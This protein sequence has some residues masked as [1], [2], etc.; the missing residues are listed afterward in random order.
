MSLPHKKGCFHSRHAVSTQWYFFLKIYFAWKF[1]RT[2][3]QKR[4]PC[5]FKLSV[6]SSNPR[7]CRGLGQKDEETQC[8]MGVCWWRRNDI[9]APTRHHWPSGGLSL[10]LRYFT[11]AIVSTWA[12][13]ALFRRGI[14]ISIIG[15]LVLRKRELLQSIIAYAVMFCIWMRF[16]SMR[17][18]CWSPVVTFTLTVWARKLTTH[19]HHQNHAVHEMHEEQRVYLRRERIYQASIRERICEA[20]RYQIYSYCIQGRMLSVC[21]ERLLLVGPRR[22]VPFGSVVKIQVVFFLL[23][24]WRLPV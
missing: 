5:F 24:R 9:K 22:M 17:K 20:K 11:C 6:R 10:L 1:I 19:I 8:T 4:L 12:F 14:S 21:M 16:L 15:W 13:C 7:T 23:G 3:L 18:N 2:I